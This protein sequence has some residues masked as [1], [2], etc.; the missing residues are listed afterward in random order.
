ME[1]PE[2]TAQLV[3]EYVD[4][5]LFIKQVLKKGLN[6][7]SRERLM[8]NTHINKVKDRHKSLWVGL[9][10]IFILDRINR[11]SPIFFIFLP[12]LPV[13][14]KRKSRYRG[15]VESGDETEK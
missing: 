7:I 15:P 1:K 11:I 2:A 12:S 3:K 13:E 14:A 10:I 9:I 4:S 6:Y 8:L 5:N